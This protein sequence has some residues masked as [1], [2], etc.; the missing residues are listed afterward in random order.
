M[1]AV[2]RTALD[3]VDLLRGMLEIPSCSGGETRL[4]AYLV[5]VMSRL[6]YRAHVDE[7]GNAVGELIRGAGPTVMLLGHIDTVPGDLPVRLIDHRLYGRGAVDAKGPMATMI[8]AAAQADFAGTLVVVG[9]VEEET[10]GSRGANHVGA[11][12]PQPDALI[13][14]EPSGWDSVVLG[15]KGKLDLRF[16]A[17]CENT[18]A[19]NPGRKA[20]ELAVEAWSLLLELLGPETS[21]QHFDAPGPTLMRVAA[22]LRRADAHFSVRLPPGF[23]ADALV[24]NVRRRLPGGEVEV[25][26]S[27]PACRVDR[28][29]PV[30]RA[31]AAGIRAQG[32][33]GRMKVKTGTSDMNTLARRWRIP[34]ATYGPGDSRLDHAD[35]EHILLPD[36]LRGIRVLTHALAE[37]GDIHVPPPGQAA[38]HP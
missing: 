28:T 7:A 24:T 23:D 26:E 17:E 16:R 14:G 5:E 32:G 19:T 34:M 3:P 12:R 18:H 38:R 10:P 35:N 31:L 11:T 2:A 15:Y 20:G 21:H 36:Y 37:L 8:C 27:V 4:A 6:G 1:S 29:D 33:R 22:D 30:V 25:L 9:A 13:I